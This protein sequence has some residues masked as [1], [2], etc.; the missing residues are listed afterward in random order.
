MWRQKTCKYLL[1]Y[2]LKAH[3]EETTKDEIYGNQDGNSREKV[4]QNKVN[5]A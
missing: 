1:E 3:D 5:D 4:K 2:M